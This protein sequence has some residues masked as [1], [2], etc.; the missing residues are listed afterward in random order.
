MSSKNT[1]F[2]WVFVLLSLLCFTSTVKADN[3][4]KP[5][6]AD[7]LYI[8]IQ[9]NYLSFGGDTFNDQTA[10]MALYTVSETMWVPKLSTGFG[11][12]ALLGFREGD[13]GM[14][15]G[16][17]KSSFD[18]TIYGD[19]YDSSLTMFNLNFKLWLSETTQLQPYLNLG[20]EL[21][22]LTAT[23]AAE[24]NASPYTL[25]DTYLTGMSVALGGGIS[26]Y[27]IPEIAL[28]LGVNYHILLYTNVSGPLD[29]SYEMEDYINGSMVNINIGL[30]CIL[31]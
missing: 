6:S 28:N 22:S 13:F 18:G 27:F 7:G 30:M 20:V 2:F 23:G 29:T 15:L 3:D 8:G 26:Y 9:G 5:V 31:N 21:C 24:L 19:V 16:F 10:Q 12:G 17:L 14:D 4:N 25:G 11:F 1:V